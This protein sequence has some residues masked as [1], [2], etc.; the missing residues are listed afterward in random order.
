[1]KKNVVR[2]LQLF[3]VTYLLVNF[4][5]RLVIEGMFPDGLTYAAIGRNMAQGNGSFW[6]PFFASSFWLPYEGASYEFWGHP[7]LAM[8]FLS[9]LYRIFGDAW[10]VEKLYCFLI[11][12]AAIASVRWL[13]RGFQ[14]DA[15]IRKLDVLALLL[16][17][18]TPI[19]L[20]SF[21]YAM[22]D[23]TM[24][25]FCF[26][27]VASGIKWASLNGENAL[28][29]LVLMVCC[30]V[31]A[32]L[33]KGPIGLF[34]LAVP[35]FYCLTHERA[36][37]GDGFLKSAGA[38]LFFMA[39]M[40]CF[41]YYPPAQ[42]FF[43]HY[44]QEQI[45]GS[46]NAPNEGSGERFDLVLIV[47]KELIPL[48]IVAILFLIFTRLKIIKTNE[49]TQKIWFWSL[50]WLSATLPMLISRKLSANYVVPSMPFA[51]FAVAQ[52]LS[53][54]LTTALASVREEAKWVMGL[55]RFCQ[56]V[57]V[58]L[59]IYCGT[60]A[61]KTQAGREQDLIEDMKLL[62]QYIPPHAQIRVCEP[63]MKDFCIHAYFQRYHF[64]QPT[65]DDTKA[66]YAI[67][68]TGC[69]PQFAS[70]TLKNYTPVAIP[71][72]EYQLFI[73]K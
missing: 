39:I 1:M 2:V 65:F 12:T 58:G 67:V 35:F 62:S 53:P 9:L 70:D 7:T 59:M 63:M 48:A 38:T 18:A 55:R 72:T 29:W 68:R 31:A 43:K 36:R 22:L 11:W 6:Q 28:K 54:T 37:W 24:S 44:F 34:P 61:G 3:V 20:W 14:S 56:V 47:R 16:W 49:N 13:W 40:A 19:V 51:A 25:V 41:W 15:E 69:A 27:A 60:I 33:T 26:L 71:T 10:W 32:V 73:K 42:N 30:L 4:V 45:M 64:W 23:N 52:W 8:W 46:I 21:P 17:Y 5:P 50:V 66:Q 57:L